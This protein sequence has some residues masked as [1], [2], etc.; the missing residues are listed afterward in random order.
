MEEI[1]PDGDCPSPRF[2]HTMTRIAPN[3]LILFGGA[4]GDVGKYSI[5]NEAYIFYI[6]SFKWA[7]IQPDGQGPS[8][9][10]AHA[11]TA[12]EQGQ[13]VIY[14]GASGGGSLIG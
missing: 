4:I 13:M 7:R 8:P 1:K 12:L 6:S 2:G 9:R 10:A 5:S 3:K 14:G 11:S